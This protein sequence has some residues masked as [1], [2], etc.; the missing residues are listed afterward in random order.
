[1]QVRDDRYSRRGSLPPP[2]RGRR[3]RSVRRPPPQGKRRPTA[4]S[5]CP[6]RR[7]ATHHYASRSLRPTPARAFPR[8]VE[9]GWVKMIV[10]SRGSRREPTALNLQAGLAEVLDSPADIPAQHIDPRVLVR[11]WC[12]TFGHIPIPLK[13]LTGNAMTRVARC[14]GD[15]RAPRGRAVTLTS[16]Y[17]LSVTRPCFRPGNK[18]SCQP[19]YLWRGAGSLRSLPALI[20]NWFRSEGN[21]LSVSRKA[22]S[23]SV[24]CAK[25]VRRRTNTDIRPSSGGRKSSISFSSGGGSLSSRGRQPASAGAFPRIFDGSFVDFRR[26]AAGSSEAERPRLPPREG[27]PG[28]RPPGAMYGQAHPRTLAST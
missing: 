18:N 14:R 15:G 26:P 6:A 16:L 24:F 12:T 17:A 5:G 21:T 4:Q 28:F 7:S 20:T 27:L 23:P 1:M 11:C 9:A 25:P 22:I 19:S 2:A 13:D 8:D 3:G 10:A